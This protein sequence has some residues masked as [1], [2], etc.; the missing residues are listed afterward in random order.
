MI[1]DDHELADGWGSFKLDP[2]GKRDELDEIFPMRKKRKLRRSDCFELLERMRQAAVQVYTEYQHAHNPPTPAAEQFD[3]AVNQGS[4]ALYFLDTR[5]HRD[6]NRGKNRILGKGQL[7]RFSQWLKELDPLQT[8]YLFLVSSVP[9][10]HMR[11]VVVN[12]DNTAVADW[13]NLQ[14]DLRDAWEHELHDGERRLLVNALFEAALR[15]IKVSIISGD[16]HTSAVF[17]MVHKQSGAVIHQLTSSAITYNK[18][19]LLGWILGETVPDKGSSK[20][21]YEFERLALYTESNF[22]MLRIDPSADEIIFQL[23]GKQ[24][25]EHPDGTEED[26]P[27]THSLMKQKLLF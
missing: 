18:P 1:W 26:R 21:G 2:G 12:A 27:V 5:G 17:R 16:V 11:S 10:M 8:R 25:V 4:I 23:Y 9:L 15:G 13:T 19:R 7:T 22:A 3:Y 6:I 24:K 20:D 14:D